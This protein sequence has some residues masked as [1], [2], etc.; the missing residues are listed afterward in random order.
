VSQE[1]LTAEEKFAIN[2]GRIAGKYVS[3][4]RKIGQDSN[5]LST[6]LTFS[7]Y[8]KTSLYRV[9]SLVC[10]GIRLAKVP[11]DKENL[12]NDMD[13]FAKENYPK[14]DFGQGNTS[15]DYAYFFHRGVYQELE[16]QI[17]RGDRA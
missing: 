3:F 12:R 1:L 13:K 7:K 8:D 5:S 10:T 2:T 15:K 9:I 14:E 6:I 16:I 11:A 4:K 17:Q